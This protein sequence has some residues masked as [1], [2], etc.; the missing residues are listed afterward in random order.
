MQASKRYDII[1]ENIYPL[2]THLSETFIRK[3]RV[4]MKKKI[5]QILLTLLLF[6]F[7]ILIISIPT[8]AAKPAATT[9]KSKTSYANSKESMTVR[10]LD[11]KKKVV[12][13]YVTKKYTATELP[14]TKCIVRKDKVYV[15]ESSK[16]VV[17]R[18]KDGK[19]L[20]TAK[21]VSAAGHL[22]KFDKN[23]NLY[24]TGYYDNYVYKVSTK[25][26]IL[27]K[28]NASK[29]N[30]YW[31]YKISISGNQMTI[32]YEMNNNDSSEK[33]HKIV[34]NIKNGKILKYS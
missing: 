24:V 20:W 32:L 34:F 15:F 18:K 16:I 33:T 29:A 19:Q 22:C 6:V 10:G 25:G 27:W 5:R 1:K 2:T 3:E 7:S 23:D 17:L 26:K 14:R 13:K 8:Q 30:N 28:T 4:Y 21:K 12:W 11:A 9:V 31:Q